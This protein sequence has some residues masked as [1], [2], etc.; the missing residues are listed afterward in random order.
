MTKYSFLDELG[1]LLAKLPKDDRREVMQDY[2]EHFAFAI[3][4]GKSDEEVI[5]SLGSPEQI[6]K[7]VIADYHVELARSSKRVKDISN[8]VRAVFAA[9]GLGFLNLVFVLGPAIAIGGVILALGIAGAMSVASP[10]LLLIASGTS[11]QAF[12]WFD[13]F[14]SLTFA[15]FGIFIS[16]A[17]YYITK[18][19]VKLMTRYLAFNLRMIKGEKNNEKDRK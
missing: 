9:G 19:M 3:E 8:A 12:Y 16:I 11:L 10:I 6:A 17:A 1:R 5:A 18:W 14:G 7:E 15:G 13:F 2:E 4:A